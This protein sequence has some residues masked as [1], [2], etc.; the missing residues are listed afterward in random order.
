MAQSGDEHLAL[1]LNA[2]NYTRYN[3]RSIEKTDEE[4]EKANISSGKRKSPRNSHLEGI[5]TTN[6]SK[7][8]KHVVKKRK[9][10]QTS[11]VRKAT[12]SLY[13]TVHKSIKKRLAKRSNVKEKHEQQLN[14]CVYTKEESKHT[15]DTK[16]NDDN[17]VESTHAVTV[18]IHEKETPNY[19]KS[20][21]KVSDVL[22][23]ELIEINND[24]LDFIELKG[25]ALQSTPVQSD[26]DINKKLCE[27]CL[28]LPDSDD[29]CNDF[30]KESIVK[31]SSDKNNI[32]N[33]DIVMTS[34]I[35]EEINEVY[36]KD[37]YHLDCLDPL[38]CLSDVNSV[39][40]PDN[41][42]QFL[43]NASEEDNSCS[44]SVSSDSSEVLPNSLVL[45]KDENAKPT[46][47]KQ[48]KNLTSNKLSTSS[49][50]LR[51]KTVFR[52]NFRYK[53]DD[54]VL[55][56]VLRFGWWFG[57][58]VKHTEKK[59]KDHAW[60]YWYGD[61]KILP[62]P[63]SSLVPY[64]EFHVRFNKSRLR[65]KNYKKAVSEFLEDSYKAMSFSFSGSLN[66]SHR[67]QNLLQWALDGFCS[68]NQVSTTSK[69]H[70]KG[71]IKDGRLSNLPHSRKSSDEGSSEN[72]SSFE[73][74]TTLESVDYMKNE[75][76]NMVDINSDVSIEN[77]SRECLLNVDND[78]LLTS[79]G[80]PSFEND[81]SITLSY[82]LDE[83]ESTSFIDGQQSSKVK[84]NDETDEI[85]RQTKYPFDGVVSNKSELDNSET[86]E[87]NV[88]S[89]VVGTSND[90]DFL[91]ENV[92]CNDDFT[93][94]KSKGFISTFVE[95]KSKEEESPGE[96]QFYCPL[97]ERN[98]RK[99]Q[100][101]T[102]DLII[103]DLKRYG[104]WFGKVVK[105]KKVL[106]KG[107]FWVHWFGDHRIN[108]IS[109][110]DLEDITSFPRRFKVANM[111][112]GIYKKAV[113]EFLLEASKRYS[114]S[115]IIVG[116]ST[117]EKHDHFKFLLKWALSG[118]QERVDKI[119]GPGVCSTPKVNGKTRKFVAETTKDENLH[120]EENNT[121]QDEIASGSVGNILKTKQTLKE[122]EEKEEGI[123]N[124]NNTTQVEGNLCEDIPVDINND[125]SNTNM[126]EEVLIVEKSEPTQVKVCKKKRTYLNL[127]N[128]IDA[129]EFVSTPPKRKVFLEATK[130]LSGKRGRK[131]EKSEDENIAKSKKSRRNQELESEVRDSEI[132]LSKNLPSVDRKLSGQNIS[133]NLND[134]MK[135]RIHDLVI[136]NVKGFG[137]WFGKIVSHLDVKQRQ[138]LK[139]CCWVFWFGD[140]SVNEMLMNSLEKMTKFS[141]RF[142]ALRI[143]KRLYAKTVQEV[144][145]EAVN[146]LPVNKLVDINDTNS[147]VDWAVNKF[148]PTG[149][150]IIYMHNHKTSGTNINQTS[151][152]SSEDSSATL[153]YHEMPSDPSPTGSDL[154]DSQLLETKKHN[155]ATSDSEQ[156]KCKLS[157]M[158]KR[159]RKAKFDN[160]IVSPQQELPTSGLHCRN[161][162]IGDLVFGK[163][164][165]FDWWFGKIISYK[166]AKQT[167][168]GDGNCWVMWYGDRKV[169]EMPIKS[170]EPLDNFKSRFMRSKVRGFYEKAVKDVLTEAAKRCSKEDT[171]DSKSPGY[172]KDLINWA[173]NGFQP[174]GVDPIYKYVE[175]DKGSSDNN[176]PCDDSLLDVSKNGE[177]EKN[178]N[179]SEI[180]PML[181]GAVKKLFDLVAVGNKNIE[182]LCLA[183]GDTKI[184]VQHPL[185]EGGL[186]KECQQSFMENAYLFDDDGY[187]MFCTICSDGQ[188][189]LLCD[190]EGCLRS[191]C[192]VCIDMFCGVGHSSKISK[193]SGNWECFI[194]T[195]KKVGILKR[196]NDWQERLKEI[197]QATF[198]H[199]N[200]APIAYYE[201]IPVEQRKPIRVLALFDGIATGCLALNQVGIDIEVYYASEI[202]TDAS[203]VARVRHGNKITHVGDV[204][205]IYKKQLDEW[206]PFDLLIGGSPCN[207]LSIANPLKKGIFGGS[208]RLFFEYYRIKELL[209]PHPI[210]SRPFFWLFENVVGMRHEDKEVITRFLQCNPVMVNSKEVSAQQRSRYFWGNLPGMSRQMFPSKSDRLNLQD[211]LEP[212][213]GRVARMNK[214]RCVTTRNHS[215]M[216]TKKAI[217]PV[218]W[219]SASNGEDGLWLTEVERIFGFPEHYTDVGNMGRTQR[220]KLL[221][222]SWSVPVVSQLFAPL[223]NYFK[224]V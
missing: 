157:P 73:K 211:C 98:L 66:G 77:K 168:P 58:V 6:V 83:T 184:V 197:F 124:V 47:V 173:L 36:R 111:K 145:I 219:D 218:K 62:F 67:F 161:L 110:D 28:P 17:I 147:L 191:Y 41:S 140:H 53:V 88:Y 97:F 24:K 92:S 198:Q 214:V 146:R 154:E 32:E 35:E 100:F 206:G 133:G 117:R 190:R 193:D 25:Q 208:G 96:V 130:A 116:K 99:K 122:K 119:F 50:S 158:K 43:L 68:T 207:D 114:R 136:G 64:T 151:D 164:A 71:S 192:T 187:Q 23:E 200:F 113:Y 163:L 186:C 127:E 102:N 202:D 182:E 30:F 170:L 179:K 143:K 104:W 63:T 115:R 160:K 74:E 3:T 108:E 9:Q 15:A 224:T 223:K 101:Q 177:K 148:Q 39:N 134:G 109:Q 118:F 11:T 172:V 21:L 159:G 166:V 162:K 194:C 142:D 65:Q 123:T 91:K 61:H 125:L 199:E 174:T 196:R 106:K 38:L 150:D 29:D 220:M 82:A 45:L 51:K 167:M 103:G 27:Q 48:L 217:L 215:L 33:D 31:D 126:C 10:K 60:V 40:N 171:F 129:S 79:Q 128:I 59:E 155:N 89:N 56:K 87:L 93:I 153:E 222:K 139:G 120:D 80:E 12:R 34:D 213:C 20:P 131:E 81:V 112:K 205:N 144:L 165:R 135:F 169:S 185:F 1:I 22:E 75:S 189:I 78:A 94:K 137:W 2:C 84:L 178:A 204:R 18:D 7:V 44:E 16:P 176:T 201:T 85:S 42:S 14:L 5:N 121:P 13:K 90:I 156:N 152:D 49:R 209:L 37:G 54:L 8:L 203:N 181:S 69:V 132:W 221:G 52:S 46:D 19:H 95:V 86:E 107:Y 195:G 183:C 76:F 70:L 72:D 57:K 149:I 141:L 180:T 210:E 4:T 175:D 26:D 55:G 188:E 138:P 216:Q 212:N 105:Q